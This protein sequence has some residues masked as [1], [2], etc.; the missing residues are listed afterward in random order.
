MIFPKNKVGLNNLWFPELPSFS[1]ATRTSS[2][3]IGF[4]PHPVFSVCSQNENSG[5]VFCLITHQMLW[6]EF[7]CFLVLFY[8]KMSA[9]FFLQVDFLSTLNFLCILFF[10]QTA[11]CFCNGMRRT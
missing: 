6:L 11:F 5:L 8:R 10:H 3:N 7:F 9:N 4:L 1:N 2:L